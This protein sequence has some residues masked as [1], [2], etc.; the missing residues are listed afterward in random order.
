MI[1]KALLGLFAV[2]ITFIWFVS[3]EAQ[4]WFWNWIF[5]TVYTN[6]RSS[7]IDLFVPLDY[8]YSSIIWNIYYNNIYSIYDKIFF[9]WNQDWDLA[10]YNWVVEWNSA[11]KWGWVLKSFYLCDYIS[12]DLDK[13]SNC[14][15]YDYNINS[16]TAYLSQTKSSDK[17]FYWDWIRFHSIDLVN[18]SIPFLAI[19]IDWI[20]KTILFYSN[21]WYTWND[22][23]YFE[24]FWLPC[25]TNT[26]NYFIEYTWSY[27]ITTFPNEYVWLSPITT[28]WDYIIPWVN[29][30]LSWD[31]IYSS[32]SNWQ[33]M[34]NYSNRYWYTY[35]MCNSDW[36]VATWY[37][38]YNTLKE[39]CQMYK[40]DLDYVDWSDPIY[41]WRNYKLAC[42]PYPEY[43]SNST[44][45]NIS[46]ID[47]TF[48]N[49]NINNSWDY[50]E[51]TPTSF[52]INLTDILKGNFYVP[53]DQ[54]LWFLPWYIVWWLL[55][56]ILFRFL[57]H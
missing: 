35:D 29:A 26:I 44:T 10:L 22:C 13:F 37:Y 30:T 33:A 21:I 24:P 6:P 31:Y 51:Q 2:S 15:Y 17:I 40:K 43:Q 20:Q 56:V 39:F 53:W 16:I 27:D 19:S 12:W 32:C 55:F 50:V 42:L 46:S 28:P 54:W 36:T 1:K 49:W 38:Q 48:W 5:N 3:A 45:W 4:T 41:T 47:L 8:S 52:L 14:V 34:Y 25:Q 57:S 9:Y 23:S 18:N 7:N 11:T